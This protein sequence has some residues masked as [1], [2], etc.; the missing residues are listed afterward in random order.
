LDAAQLVLGFILLDTV[1]DE[2]AFG[3]IQEAED[4]TRLFEVNNVHKA[5]GVVVVGAD[6]AVD[7]DTSLHADLLAFLA[8]QSVLETF[9]EDD[10][11]REAFALFVG[12]L[13]GFGGPDA[14]HFAEVPMAGRIEALEVFLGSARPDDASD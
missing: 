5:G 2:T 3:I 8:R 1:E 4:I 7:L 9:A 13:R 11:D 6:L 14:A 10:A 12:A